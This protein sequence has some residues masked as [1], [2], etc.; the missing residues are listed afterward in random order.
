MFQMV[1]ERLFIPQLSKI[2]DEDKKIMCN[3]S[4]TFIV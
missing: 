4:N 2:D 3:C 1:V